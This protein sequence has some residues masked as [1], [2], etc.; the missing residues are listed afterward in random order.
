MKKNTTI[1]VF[2]LTLGMMLWPSYGFC[3]TSPKVKKLRDFVIYENPDYYASFPSVIKKE[4]GEILVAFRRAPDRSVFNESGTNHV[5]PNSYL[6]SVRS[7]D[8][9]LS[10]SKEPELIY[11]HPFGG[12]RKS[13]V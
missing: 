6:V 9:G 1:Y 11:A 8:N 5:D 12:D 7:R 13:V 10:W 3:Q 4:D 2:V